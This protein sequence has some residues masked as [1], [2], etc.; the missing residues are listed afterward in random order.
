MPP[1]D[2]LVAT[3]ASVI[4]GMILAHRQGDTEAIAAEI[5]RLLSAV[6]VYANTPVERASD[7]PLRRAV[8]RLSVNG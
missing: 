8:A 2:E 6:A 4:A 3:A 7:E 1:T 5:G